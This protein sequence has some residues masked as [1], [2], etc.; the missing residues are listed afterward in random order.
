[1]NVEER[2]QDALSAYRTHVTVSPQLLARIE[3]RIEP[4]HAWWNPRVVRQLAVAIVVVV[5]LATS[6]AVL[7]RAGSGGSDAASHQTTVTGADRTCIAVARALAEKRIVFETA[8]AYESVAAARVDIANA[9]ADRVRRLG[10]PAR[11]LAHVD[12]AIANF[13]SAADAADRARVAARRGDLDAA[14]DEFTR[15][16]GA[17]ERAQIDL[18]TIGAARCTQQ[19]GTR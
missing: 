9:A 18:A 2:L 16:D 13:E 19:G 5:L 11:D 10:P 1:M 7:Q 8:A 14:R 17:I 4:R 12:S 3:A 15:F 6:I